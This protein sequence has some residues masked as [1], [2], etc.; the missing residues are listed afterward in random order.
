MNSLTKTFKFDGVKNANL[1]RNIFMALGDVTGKLL[2]SL[3]VFSGNENIEQLKASMN[4]LFMILYNPFSDLE[5]EALNMLKGILFKLI[6]NFNQIF[7]EKFKFFNK[8][9]FFFNKYNSHRSRS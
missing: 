9:F 1:L 2:E 4:S 7:N 8:F 3:D 5:I 6:I